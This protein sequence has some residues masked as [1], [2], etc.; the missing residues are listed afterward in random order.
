MKTERLCL[1]I[2]L[3]LLAT[4]SSILLPADVHLEL[5]GGL[6]LMNPDDLNSYPEVWD[7]YLDFWYRDRLE[8]EQQVG[9]IQSYEVSREGGFDTIHTA[10]PWGLRLR[11]DLTSTLAVSL[12]I[13]RLDTGAGSRCTQTTRVTAL[14]GVQRQT[15]CD[16][17]SLDIWA[18]AWIPQLGIHHRRQLNPKTGLEFFLCGGP[19]L[20]SC[21]LGYDYTIENRENDEIVS[22]T[23]RVVEEKGSG[24][25]LNLEAF[26]RLDRSLGKT[27]TAFVEA[28]FVYQRVTELEG[29]GILEE[30]GVLD[31]WE[32]EWGM[33]VN[34]EA[35][36]WG[37][38]YT[39]YPSNS[40]E[41]PS[42]LIW[43]RSFILDL[44]GFQLRAGVRLR[45]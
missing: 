16:F 40:W 25:G 19:V 4:C 38:F 28:G 23:H 6:S 30:N 31:I 37:Q 22:S 42:N 21:R 43:A 10:L 33:K 2:I 44:S 45:L 34:Y 39:L 5:F 29:P 1:A 7:G 3:I 13:K 8:Y 35:A 12:G 27:V 15:V 14:D 36:Y 18:G 11:F 32:G 26:V 24:Q 20:G 9:Y 17:T 41:Y